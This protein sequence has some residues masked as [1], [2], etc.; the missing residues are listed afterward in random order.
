MKKCGRICIVGKMLPDIAGEKKFKLK[1]INCFF[2]RS[3]IFFKLKWEMLLC[4]KK[5]KKIILKPYD[6]VLSFIYHSANFCLY[7]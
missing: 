5:K 4:E 2:K 7:N 6:L 3:R 1:K